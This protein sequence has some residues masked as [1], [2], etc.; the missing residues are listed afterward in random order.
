[1]PPSPLS[2][3]SRSHG[4]N[5]PIHTYL[6]MLGE[7]PKLGV[8]CVIVAQRRTLRYLI[9]AGEGCAGQFPGTGSPE[10]HT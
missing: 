4:R 1:M 6:V 2:Q 7:C 10:P 8:S 5:T 3:S 9:V